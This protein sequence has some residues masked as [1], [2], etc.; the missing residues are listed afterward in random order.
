MDGSPRSTAV[1]EVSVETTTRKF[2]EG[3]MQKLPSVDLSLPQVNN[4]TKWRRMKDPSQPRNWP[5]WRKI[6]DT[7]VSCVLL[8]YI[9][10]LISNTG[11]RGRSIQ[12]SIR[13]R[14]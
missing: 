9:T 14:N 13:A 6:Y 1:T 3:E 2:Y 10:T 4:V 11:V 7:G 8:E 12:F 5:A